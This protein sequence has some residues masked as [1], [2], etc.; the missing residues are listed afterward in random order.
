MG[1]DGSLEFF[2]FFLKKRD[3]LL[4]GLE[5]EFFT[6]AGALCVFTVAFPEIVG[7]LVTTEGSK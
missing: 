6:D 2:V 4:E 1:S 7:K 3:A 5:K